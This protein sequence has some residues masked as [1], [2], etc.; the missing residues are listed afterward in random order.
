MFCILEKDNKTF[1]YIKRYI[2]FMEKEDRRNVM[3][4][5]NQIQQEEMISH[6]ERKGIDRNNS[7]IVL[8]ELKDW[9]NKNGSPIRVYINTI[10]LAAVIFYTRDK[11][12]FETC[13]YKEFNYENFSKVVDDI[14]CIRFQMETLF[15]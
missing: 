14:N 6:L 8:Q 12:C 3:T 7:P 15:A 10:K 5:D 11:D 1:L 9:I 2:D 4:L 13:M